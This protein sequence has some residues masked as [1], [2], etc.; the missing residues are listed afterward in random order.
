MKNNTEKMDERDF[1]LC[2]PKWFRLLTWAIFALMF[3]VYVAAGVE[4]FTQ[5]PGDV[6]LMAVGFPVCVVLP[7]FL[8]YFSIN[9]SVRVDDKY[10]H[11]KSFSLKEKTVALKSIDKV[12]L[13]NRPMPRGSVS[14]MLIYVEFKKVLSIDA[15]LTGYDLLKRRLMKEN[16]PLF[17]EHVHPWTG[18]GREERLN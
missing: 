13:I 14:G 6:L 2:F 18:K 11:G 10:I 1:T 5:P 8:I 4:I 17:V 9:A 7:V 3:G 15:A 16:I 12:L